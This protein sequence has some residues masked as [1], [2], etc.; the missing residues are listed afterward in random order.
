MGPF[1]HWASVVN[2][3]ARWTKKTL[4]IT[5]NHY[6]FPRS[7]L[8]GFHRAWLIHLTLEQVC[9]TRSAWNPVPSPWA[10][11]RLWLKLQA[12]KISKKL[13]EIDLWKKKVQ[14]KPVASSRPVAQR[15]AEAFRCRPLKGTWWPGGNKM[16]HKCRHMSS[17]NPCCAL[18]C[19]VVPWLCLVQDP[20][21][22]LSSLQK[23]SLSWD[24]LFLKPP[25]KSL[26]GI[27]ISD[28]R[29]QT[30]LGLKGEH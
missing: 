10:I 12:V 23:S 9:K 21:P 22:F 16:S 14:C 13:C 17:Q 4:E 20:A 3:Q 27:H 15:F 11:K 5:W 6:S 1:P 19:H 7:V 26:G 30:G 28:S 29:F 18:L 25:E 2:P 24:I 8:C